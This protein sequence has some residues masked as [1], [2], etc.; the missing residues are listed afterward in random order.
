MATKNNR[1]K[2][3][4]RGRAVQITAVEEIRALLGDGSLRRDLLIEYL[5]LIQDHYRCISDE[6]CVAIAQE[7]RISSAE[8]YEVATFYHHFDVVK[9]DDARPPAITV[10]VCDSLTCSLFGADALIASLSTHT[11]DV[12]IQHVPCVGRCAAAPV[13]VVGTNAIE[14]ATVELI[15]K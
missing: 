12:R 2:G 1:H 5:H 14:N 8:V 15:S 10:R 13:A 4:S 7:L 3:Q 11:D 6:H 9:D